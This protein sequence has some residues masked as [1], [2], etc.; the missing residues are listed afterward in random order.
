M[1]SFASHWTPARAESSR[2]SARIGASD[3]MRHLAACV[4]AL[5]LDVLFPRAADGQTARHT[6]RRDVREV[7]R[8]RI[9]ERLEIRCD[10]VDLL[11]RE[12]Q[13]VES[14]SSRRQHVLLIR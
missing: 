7:T 3:R 10:I 12:N 6:A 2:G 5:R 9:R 13:A 8:R 11:I 4:K 1:P 14:R